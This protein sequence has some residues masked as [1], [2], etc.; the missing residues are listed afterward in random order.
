M[1]IWPPPKSKKLKSVV[2]DT[3]PIQQDEYQGVSFGAA[4][5][6]ARRRGMKEFQWLNPKTGEIG[7]FHT[8]YK[9]EMDPKPNTKIEV[10]IGDVSNVDPVTT[11]SQKQDQ[12]GMMNTYGEK[13]MNTYSQP[14]GKAMNTYGK[15]MSQFKTDNVLPVP[16]T[17][18]NRPGQREFSK[19]LADDIV[20]GM[21]IQLGTFGLGAGINAL[22]QGSK[23]M[24]NAYQVANTSR[25]GLA[26]G[27]KALG[28]QTESM[29]LMPAGS[30]VVDAI[31]QGVNAGREQLRI[32]QILKYLEQTIAKAK[33]LQ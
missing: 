21:A 6:D 15:D 23:G 3:N 2:T 29:N 32:Q 31:S 13:P 12:V 1:P 20:K 18:Q 26:P 4:F 28:Y 5:K 14:K 10:P 33:N 16:P 27:M 24:V 7:R 17:M 25:K 8:R 19:N 11:Y 22:T 9:E 30:N